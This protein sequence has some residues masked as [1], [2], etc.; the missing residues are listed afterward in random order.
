[1]QKLKELNIYD[2]TSIIITTDHG[3]IEGGNDHRS[4]PYAGEYISPDLADPDCYLIWM[5]SNTIKG[6]RVGLQND[7]AE[8]IYGLFGIDYTKFE[9]AVL[10]VPV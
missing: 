8:T 10:C 3:F 7:I 2:K 5:I 9:P 6:D 4:L 1:V